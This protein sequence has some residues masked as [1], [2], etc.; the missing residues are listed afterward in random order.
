MW[1]IIWIYPELVKLATLQDAWIAEINDIVNN[2][3]QDMFSK[4][5]PTENAC[6]ATADAKPVLPPL[7]AVQPARRV[8]PKWAG[9][10]PP[11]TT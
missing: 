8:S 11:P 10:V 1:V 6:V 4:A 2:A 5:H 9:H 7:Q 3:N